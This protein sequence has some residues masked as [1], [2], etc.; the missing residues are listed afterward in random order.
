MSDG[1]P[2]M[3]HLRFSPITSDNLMRIFSALILFGLVATLFVGCGPSE[4]VVTKYPVSGTVTFDSKPLESGTIQFTNPADGG[5][6]QM[7]VKGGSFKGEVRAGKRKVEITAMREAGA[8]IFPGRSMTRRPCY[9]APIR[10]FDGRSRTGSRPER[11]GP[12]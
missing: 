10:R 8:A 3:A 9:P 5:I 7:D 6:D 12:R 4:P 2:G 11:C 1:D